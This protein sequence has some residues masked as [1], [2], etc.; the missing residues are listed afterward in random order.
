V[1]LRS[2]QAWLGHSDLES[3]MRYLRPAKGQAVRDR[4]EATFG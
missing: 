2:L 1:D 3:T 4:V